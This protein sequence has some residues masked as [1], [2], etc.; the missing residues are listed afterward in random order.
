MEWGHNQSKWVGGALEE[1]EQARPTEEEGEE[2][3]EGPQRK[4]QAHWEHEEGRKGQGHGQ[5]C[6]DDKQSCP[7]QQE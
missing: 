5:H 2:T 1:T 3:L 6:N 7:Q 4:G